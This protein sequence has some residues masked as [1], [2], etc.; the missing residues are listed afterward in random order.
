MYSVAHAT[1]AVP[2]RSR[3][4]RG[5]VVAELVISSEDNRLS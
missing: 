2:P 3:R 5:R 1:A 4:M